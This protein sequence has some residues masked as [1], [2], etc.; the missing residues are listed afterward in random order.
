MTDLFSYSFVPR[1]DPKWATGIVHTGITIHDYVVNP[2]GGV[3]GVI[4]SRQ[5]YYAVALAVTFKRPSTFAPKS[6]RVFSAIISPVKTAVEAK[7]TSIAAMV[8]FK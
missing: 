6:I 3:R 7:I 5:G 1:K 2:R 8:P 4:P